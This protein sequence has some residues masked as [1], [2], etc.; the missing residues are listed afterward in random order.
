[1]DDDTIMIETTNI[2]NYDNIINYDIIRLI[3]DINNN[4]THTFIYNIA[5]IINQLNRNELIHEYEI[6][7][8]LSEV[9]KKIFSSEYEHDI[10][11]YE[12]VEISYIDKLKIILINKNFITSTS[13]KYYI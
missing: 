9:I 6:F 12:S 13:L 10:S 3:Y 5:N 8:E 4:P 1:M 7:D 11:K 2:K